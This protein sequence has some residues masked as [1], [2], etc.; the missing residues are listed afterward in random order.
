MLLILLSIM[1]NWHIVHLAP[2]QAAFHT[3]CTVS[4]LNSET[5]WTG[6][7]LTA[8]LL[9]FML[10]HPLQY[11]ACPHH[12]VCY[13][14]KQLGLHH[15]TA[16][17]HLKHNPSC[18]K[19]LQ[20]TEWGRGII[21]RRSCSTIDARHA[22]QTGTEVT[23]THWPAAA[24]GDAT[25]PLAAE[26]AKWVARPQLHLTQIKQHTTVFRGVMPILRC[27]RILWCGVKFQRLRKLR[28]LVISIKK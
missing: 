13:S 5:C 28:A 22:A 21:H 6:V 16:D 19:W 14:S 8:V 17:T 20:A 1:V 25:L 26:Q 3:K 9:H 11:A 18:S 12:T 15:I 23:V 10:S 7:T 2:R 27:C 4:F 24:T